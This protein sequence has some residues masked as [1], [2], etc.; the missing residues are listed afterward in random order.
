MK[1]L[2]QKSYS[3][4]NELP[5][6]DIKKHQR[7]TVN[8][9]KWHSK[10]NSQKNPAYIISKVIKSS[11]WF[12]G[13]NPNPFSLSIY[14]SNF[15]SVRLR[16]L[17]IKFH[18][19]IAVGLLLH[20]FLLEVLSHLGDWYPERLKCKKQFF[21]YQWPLIDFAMESFPFLL[22]HIL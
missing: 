12:F 4:K 14:C 1:I 16:F 19:T 21:A 13:V 18:K 17:V 3:E 9:Y 7:F 8:F 22:H 2:W 6:K 11:F 15:I 5:F 10:K 20:K